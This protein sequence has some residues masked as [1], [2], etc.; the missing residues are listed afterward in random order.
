M[1]S[2]HFIAR[3][4]CR[5]KVSRAWRARAV[6]FL[7]GGWGFRCSSPGVPAGIVTHVCRL[8]ARSAVQSMGS[9]TTW[10]ISPIPRTPPRKTLLDYFGVQ[11]HAGTLCSA[12]PG[13][14]PLL[15]AP[16]APK[17]SPNLPAEATLGCRP[18][19]P[20]VPRLGCLASTFHDMYI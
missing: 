7:S 13:F 8:T 14:S 19:S 18:E 9:A 2:L 10:V 20:F 15:V 6:W 12:R 5:A 4:V 3:G 17:A 16:S 1:E 11:R